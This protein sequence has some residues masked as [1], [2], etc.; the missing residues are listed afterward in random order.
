MKARTLTVPLMERADAGNNRLNRTCVNGRSRELLLEIRELL[1]VF[2]PAGDDYQHSLWIEVPR[3]KPSDWCSFSHARMNAE[4]EPY[5]RADYL[6]EWKANYPME[7]QWYHISVSRYKGH[8]YL[9]MSENDHWWC[10][11]HDDDNKDAYQEDMEWLLEPLA[12]FLR[13]KVP[14]IAA[15][16]EAYNRYVDGHLPKRQRTGRIA[17]K[18]LDRIVPWQRRRPRNVKKVIKMLKECIENEKIYWMTEPKWVG[19]KWEKPDVSMENVALPASYREPLPHM[20]IRIYAKYFRVAYMAYEEHFRHLMRRGRREREAYGAFLEKVS[21]M[22][23]IEFY[24]RYQHGSHGEITDET[25][26]DSEEAFKEMAVDHYGELG[27]SRNDVH[28]VDY[29]TPGKWLISFGVSYSAWVD[30][31]CEI[32][33]A[34]YEA[35]A[36]LLLYDAQKMLDILEGKDYVKLTPHTFHDYL[37]H[38]G[39]GSV[40]DLPYECYLG[41][42]DEITREQYDEIVSLATWEPEDELKLDEPV[43]LE[44]AVYD[45][46]RDEV[47][48]PMTV[49]KIL[50][51]LEEKYGIGVGIG[52]YSNHQHIYLYGWKTGDD[53]IQIKDTEFMPANEAMLAILRL[54]AKENGLAIAKARLLNT[55]RVKNTK[56]HEE[57]TAEIKA[58]RNEKRPEQED[59]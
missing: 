34:L 57:I 10:Q 38:H 37:N 56:S 29:F 43:Q 8:T 24:R 9:H 39:E 2:A 27:L 12:E 33:L 58:Y 45:P 15:D 17:R 52:H 41:S 36:P 50:E 7:S 21:K 4:E 55:P 31:G 26:F 23:D 18:Q 20:S 16:V 28:A 54:F 6:K 47:S 35:G 42:G 40:F 53:K 19:N 22:T 3:G 49:C 14:E 32:A 5:T 11:I 59:E 44:D 1:N 48:E 30:A 25:D 13:E 51:R 46:I